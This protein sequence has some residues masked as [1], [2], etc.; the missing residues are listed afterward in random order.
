M[1]ISFL[2]GLFL[3]ITISL[4]GRQKV[5]DFNIRCQQAYD[6]IMQLRLDAGA[7]LLE[8][9]KKAHPDN[10]IPYFLENYADFFTLFFNEDPALY[11]Q[12]KA[13]R[14]DRLARMEEGPTNSPY[15]LYTQAAI[16]FQWGMIRVKF[17]EKWDAVWDIRK[18]YLL[19]KDNQKKFPQFLPNNM[20]AGSMQTVFGT[21]P[22]G[23]RWISNTL[24]MKGSIREGMQLVQQVIDSNTEVAKLFREEACYYYCY[25]KLFI[26][27]KPEDVWGFI[28]KYKLDTKN[29]YLFAL[30]VANIAMNNQ[31]ATLGIKILTERNDS[32]QY[33][34]IPYVYYV[35]GQLKLCRGDEDANVYLL[36]FVDRFKGKFYLKEGLQRLSWYYYLHNNMDAANKYRNMILTR[37]NTETDADKQALK[38][39]KSG[40]WP[41]PLLLKARLLSDGGFFPDALKLLQT[42]KAADFAS[43][44]EKLEY[45]YRLG[46]IYD[47]MGMDDS[48]ITMY[49][50]TVRTGANRQE[51]FAAR[52]S[53]QMGYIYEKRNDKAKA[54][55]CYQACLDMKGHDYKNSLD[56]RA[57][58]GIQR[59]NGS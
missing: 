14:A 13:L 29:N 44:E 16:R 3:S 39:A 28:Q 58:A 7:A 2:L 23:Y 54:Q 47:E 11:A 9:E 27:N 33:E 5:Y 17:S 59:L 1:R 40:R 56:Q 51:Y 49:E 50:V 46:R 20:L 22:E 34:E 57:K 42:K 15:Y 38:D 45:A 53:L 36:K 12:K 41:H 32:V 52:A 18:A 8:E 37:G 10:L 4:T 6:A 43:M 30:M 35:L 25:L 19:L 24:G 31:K 26:E 21:I 55:K 48:A